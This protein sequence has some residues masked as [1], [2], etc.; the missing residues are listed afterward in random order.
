MEDL[1]F[2]FMCDTASARKF[3]SHASCIR[4]RRMC[5]LLYLH[6]KSNQ[7]IKSLISCINSVHICKPNRTNFQSIVFFS[8]SNEKCL[9]VLSFSEMWRKW[10]GWGVSVVVIGVAVGVSCTSFIYRPQIVDICVAERNWN[11][12]IISRLLVMF[13]FFFSFIKIIGKNSYSFYW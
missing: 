12:W 4:K 1:W 7:S 3:S 2:F 8:L 10:N 9:L 13:V 11:I 6:I 5:R